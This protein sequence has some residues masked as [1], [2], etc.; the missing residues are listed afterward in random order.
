[1]PKYTLDPSLLHEN[2]RPAV[3]TPF[4]SGAPNGFFMTGTMAR[5]VFVTDDT[6]IYVRA[7]SN[8][9]ERVSTLVAANTQICYRVNGKNRWGPLARLGDGVYK[10]SLVVPYGEATFAKTVELFTPISTLSSYGAPLT[11][12]WFTEIEA[13]N[14]PITFIAPVTTGAHR[15][16]Y[17]DSIGAGMFAIN[18]LES[19]AGLMKLGTSDQYNPK[20]KGAWVSGTAYA[21]GDLFSYSGS[22]WKVLNAQVAGTLPT[23]GANFQLRG[24]LGR[25]TLVAHGTRRLI[26][27]CNGSTAWTA[28][29]TYLA[30]LNPTDTIIF[31]GV[32]DKGSAGSDT[33]TVYQAN[34]T[35]LL[36]VF[37]TLNTNPVRVVSPLITAAYETA[38]ANGDTLDDFRTGAQNAVTN[39]TN[40]HVSFV[41]GKTILS[42]AG[43]DLME[44]LHPLTGGHRTI[45]LLLN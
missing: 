22:T 19:Y 45:R 37:G 25:V 42:L 8:E 31:I 43:D 10:L 13:L 32:N 21:A 16:I 3:F 14:S 34:L 33:K 17:S 7:W 20:W 35:G 9:A 4:V 39:T 12:V 36:N 27:D 41:N 29:A 30:S 38:N 5:Y 18:Q 2:G 11:G 6:E 28:F 1:M 23:E 44:G 26:D 15:V 40:T 24:F